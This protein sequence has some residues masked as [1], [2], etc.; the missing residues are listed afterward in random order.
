MLTICPSWKATSISWPLIWVRTVTIASGVTV[1]SAL[2]MTGMSPFSTAAVPTGSGPV[3][4]KRP[5]WVA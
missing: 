4:V 5:V 1:P 2:T 3:E